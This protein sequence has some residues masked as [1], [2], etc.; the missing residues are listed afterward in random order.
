VL[1]LARGT[2]PSELPRARVWLSWILTHGPIAD[3]VCVLHRC[4]NPPCVNPAHLFLGTQIDNV[5]DMHAKGRAAEL[6]RATGPDSPNAL[7]TA[8]Q[9]REIW[10]LRSER[11]QTANIAALYGASS[12]ALN[13]LFGRRVYREVTRDLPDLPRIN[14]WNCL[15]TMPV[16]P[17][18]AGSRIAS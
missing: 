18:A 8:D 14:R 3:G 17:L 2:Q 16:R 7:F 6:K 9:V 10:Q 15:R 13:Q 11:Y 12:A 5:R 1:A 4:D